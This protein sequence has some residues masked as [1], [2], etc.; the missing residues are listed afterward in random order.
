[1]INIINKDTITFSLFFEYF[2]LINLLFIMFKLIYTTIHDFSSTS[3]IFG[4]MLSR[5]FSNL[6]ISDIAIDCYYYLRYNI[7]NRLNQFKKDNLYFNWIF[8]NGNPPF[9]YDYNTSVIKNEFKDIFNKINELSTN[10][11]KNIFNY[12]NTQKPG[13]TTPNTNTET[14]DDLVEENHNTSPNTDTE[15]GNNL[16][17]ETHNTSLNSNIETIDDLVKENHNTSPN[18]NIETSDDLVKENH[19]TSPNTNIETSD[20]LVEDNHNTS[21]NTNIETS[22]NLVEDNHN[23]SPNTNTETSDNLVED[24]HNTSPNI[25]TET[26]DDLNNNLVDNILNQLSN[27]N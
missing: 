3:F 12:V 14:D 5:F 24:N 18:T 13:Y 15:T 2:I 17:E 23:T 7:Y 20:D 1:M 6:S 27:S 9:K 11:Y 26:G 22:D 10:S 19:N 21:P 16:V 8:F 25:N 4:F